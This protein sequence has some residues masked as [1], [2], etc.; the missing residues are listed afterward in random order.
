MGRVVTVV[1][2]VNLALVVLLLY[3][4]VTLD[5][6]TA[7]PS[8][9][10][11]QSPGS[12]LDMTSLLSEQNI[13]ENS[14]PTLSLA[15]VLGR[16]KRGIYRYLVSRP[17]SFKIYRNMQLRSRDGV[18]SWNRLQDAGGYLDTIGGSIIGKRVESARDNIPLNTRDD[19]SWS[20]I[21]GN[22]GYLDT[23]GGSIIGKRNS[24][25]VQFDDINEN[26]NE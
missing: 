1:Y 7:E 8:N 6:I 3:S 5:V 15:R 19:Y 23:I 21:Q 11:K 26:E 10:A 25:K 18:D 13:H 14:V 24:R 12:T 22:G 9:G 16:Q 2:S 4:T 17:E 20:G